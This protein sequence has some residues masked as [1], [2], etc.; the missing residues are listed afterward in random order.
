MIMQLNGLLQSGNEIGKI[1]I[2]HDKSCFKI[3]RRGPPAPVPR[4]RRSDSLHEFSE[5]HLHIVRQ[6]EWKR[7]T[8]TGFTRFTGLRFI[9]FILSILSFLSFL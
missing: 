7:K 5:T 3:S 4:R 6:G 1:G 2:G 9:L 8:P